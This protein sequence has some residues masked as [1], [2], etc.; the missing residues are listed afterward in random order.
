VGLHESAEFPTEVKEALATNLM[1]TEGGV[2]A[3][4]AV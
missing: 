1:T 2:V 3:Q 4:D